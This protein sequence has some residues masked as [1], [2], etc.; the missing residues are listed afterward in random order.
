MRRLFKYTLILILSTLFLF[1][2]FLSTQSG[3]KNLYR[4]LDLYASYKLDMPIEI[5]E[6]NISKLPYIKAKALL[7]QSY[8]T[9]I[10]GT[11]KNK[12]MQLR[13][14]LHS[15]RLI[16]NTS[17]SNTT[18][19]LQGTIKGWGE[20]IKI[21]GS[22]D[23]FDGHVNYDFKKEN[24]RYKDIHL[25]I[26]DI[27]ISKLARV[28][29]RNIYAN[30]TISALVN[31]DTLNDK[32]ER[33]DI[34]IH[35]K[36]NK[37][38]TITG[39]VHHED[40][41]RQIRGDATLF[42]GKV[43]FKYKRDKLYVDL[44]N[45][46]LRLL[47]NT[48]EFPAI[49]DSNITG[50]GIYNLTKKS[51]EL[52]TTLP[53]ATLL[54]SAF[55]K[56]LE[57]K[58]SLSLQKEIFDNS[59]LS[60]KLNNNLLSSKLTLANKKMHLKL[61]DTVFNKNY[62]SLR[63]HIDIQMPKHSLK[64]T[65]FIRD[66]GIQTSLF[67]E[68]YLSFNG[69]IQQHYH[70]K[71]DGILSQS[72]INIAYNLAAKRLP[73]PSVTIVDDINLSGH[74]NGDYTQLH[75][76]GKGMAMEGNVTFKG[77]KEKEH[78]ENLMLGFHHIHALKLFTLL[79]K[80]DFPNGK[81]DLNASLSYIDAKQI[82][83]K[84]DFLLKNGHYKTLPLHLKVQASVNKEQITFT[85]H[86]KLAT[87]DINI[88]NGMYKF[89]TGTYKSFYTVRTNNLAP[90]EPLIG[91]YRGKFSATGNIYYNG[92]VQIRGLS[93]TFG[94]IVDFLYKENMLY[95]DLEKV[96]LNRLMNLFDSP[97]MLDAQ[98]NGN[99]NYNYT[100]EQLL[101]RADLNN[102][103]FLK[104]DLVDTV[105]KKSGINMLKEVFPNSRLFAIY[106]H[107]I[108]AGDLILQNK[109]SHFIIKNTQINTKKNDINAHFNLRMQGQAFSGRVYGNI[110]NPQIKLDLK[111]LIRY[112]M[113]KQVDS[114]IGKHNRELME[115][116]PMG[117]V[118]KDM[119]TDMGAELMD[120][121]F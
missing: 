110:E 108:L 82:H 101:F 61:H 73:G 103:I 85:S 88:S 50:K 52:N 22:G 45:I 43:I 30:N 119:A 112:Q 35:P 38:F 60:L 115:S 120:M 70:L 58:T 57:E 68:S 5:Q 4:L 92:G 47:M 86:A 41:N 116:M 98:V 42:Q 25:K 10:E 69:L 67:Q 53:R 2:Y 40:K 33:F 66:T 15:N 90:L 114:V 32:K 1:F 87:A 39:T 89:K 29:D 34:T 23:A 72:F 17:T 59:T 111:K 6:I 46:S 100:K 13:Y 31:F 94:G 49:L 36:H 95:I 106:Q 102:S 78:I 75:F 77:I 91:K 121:F 97:K 9:H 62:N 24:K 26:D 79:G 113:D 104:S 28:L 105:F 11:I 44:K 99:I 80:P 54:P 14:T 3:Q 71:L 8:I 93:P 96:S 48:F 76:S 118:A 51:L 12:K 63:T 37:P 107:N 16:N 84:I 64:G 7:H 18:I 55:L 74:I 109:Q 20:K 56:S 27:N 19:M 65:L 83:G 21:T 117:D 81:A